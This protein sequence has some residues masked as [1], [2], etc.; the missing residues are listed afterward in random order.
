[1]TYLYSI[2]HK[3]SLRREDLKIEKEKILETDKELEE[4]YNDFNT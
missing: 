3:W 1:M 2:T 4:Y